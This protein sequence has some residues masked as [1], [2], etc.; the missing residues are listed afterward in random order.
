MLAIAWTAVLLAAPP[1]GAH[2]VG[3]EVA[4]LQDPSRPLEGRPRPIQMSLWYPAARRAPTELTFG[5]YVSLVGSELGPAT[6]EEAHV[7]VEEHASFLRSRAKMSEDDVERWLARPMRAIARAEPL[8]GRVPLILVAQGSGNSA[9]DQ[10]VL[11]EILASHGFAVATSPSPTRIAGPMK[12]EEDIAKTAE[13][14]ALDLAV[15]ARAARERP[16]VDKR[17]TALVAHSFGARSALLYAMRDGA[18]ALVSL[19]GG[20]GTKTGHD[21]LR[22]SRFF[23]AA[24]ATLPILHIYEELDA[25]MAPD[26]TLLRSLPAD[27]RLVRATHL[28]HMHFTAVGEA[29][30]QFPALAKVTHAD[31]RTAQAYV[32]VVSA[33]VSFLE[34]TLAAKPTRA[35]IDRALSHLGKTLTVA[36][37]AH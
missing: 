35:G 11:C 13:D 37:R 36:N 12:S 25:F 20:I 18:A 5:D 34:A 16:F 9:S 14:Q 3:F 2:P 19:D 29:V 7:A 8:P 17:Q 22:K 21:E 30:G 24:K 31:A 32:D 15:L 26:F 28:H 6:P 23:D 27:L 33:T 10:A 1:W 4:A